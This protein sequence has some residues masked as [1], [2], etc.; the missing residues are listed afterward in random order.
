MPEPPE[1]GRPIKF[2][3]PTPKSSLI[4][5]V[6]IVGTGPAGLSLARELSKTDLRIC[7]LESGGRKADA[8]MA[9][10]NTGG[11]ESPQG[12]QAETL[13]VGR[14]RQLG[15]SAN[16]WNHELR[17][18]RGKFIRCVAL[19]EIDFE[20]RDWIPLSG[21]PF[22][23]RDLAP[24]YE[25]AHQ[26]CRIGPFGRSAEAWWHGKSASAPPLRIK[27][28]ESVVT[29]FCSADIFQKDYQAEL[30]KAA[31][32][33]LFTQSVLLNLRT[34]KKS[35][36]VISSVEV[37]RADGSRFVVKARLVVLAAGGLENTRILLLNE[38]TRNGGPGNQHDL[39]GRCFMDHPSITLGTLTPS[40]AGVYDR[41]TFY[42]Q[43]FVNGVPIMGQLRLSSEVMR[44]EKL[45]N[46]CAV[47]VPHFKNLRS[48]LPAVIKQIAAKGPRYLAG[49]LWPEP[50]PQLQYQYDSPFENEEV[51]LSLRQ[52]LLEGYY[53]ERFCGWS[54]VNDK[55]RHFGE[56]GVRSLVEQ[57]PDLANRIVLGGDVDAFG[58]QRLKLFWRWSE[59]DLRSIRRT[60]EVLRDEFSA[61]G[62][63]V[64]TP[65]RESA[66]AKP[67][68]FFSPHHFMGT[69]RMHD[70]PR[71]GVVDAN[72][73]VHGLQNLFVTGSSVFP[74]GGFANPT[75]T[76][77]AL[78]LRLSDHLHYLLTNQ[79]PP[80]QSRTPA[81]VAAIPN[82]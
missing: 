36:D 59:I 48:N 43:H 56:I 72:C 31:N 73:R 7:V 78:A 5:D 14:R 44:R 57:S 21:W 50:Q 29:Q 53:S 81:P 69:T 62:M 32:V 49:R 8:A 22:S 52:R 33:R 46:A 40:S 54:R 15:G 45:L 79:K 77:V 82:P 9:D 18:Q 67:R 12:Y 60:Q 34:E 64:F 1:L 80:S 24:F 3:L 47:L 65:T 74:T 19:D 10:L 16:L 41:T 68:V 61:A 20:R 71:H 66:G 27:A 17:G 55:A 28:L 2:M 39:V 37:A 51:P 76:I 26:A 30:D 58:Q 63:G 13:R 42:D 70:N 11:V 25:R 6:C 38:A 35:P 23:L 75:L 4:A